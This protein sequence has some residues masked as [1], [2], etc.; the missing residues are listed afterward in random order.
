[1]LTSQHDY[2]ISNFPDAIAFNAN[3]TGWSWGWSGGSGLGRENSV[4]DLHSKFC[5]V[6]HSQG[7]GGNN[8]G[9]G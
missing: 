3:V 6:I 8:E 9:Y 5:P 4:G 7:C 1:M 2:P